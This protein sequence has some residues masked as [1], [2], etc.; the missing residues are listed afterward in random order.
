ML[1]P[2]FVSLESSLYASI[3]SF[4]IHRSMCAVCTSCKHND[5]RICTLYAADVSY[6][7]ICKYVHLSTCLVST[8]HCVRPSLCSPVH[9]F[10]YHGLTVF[11]RPLVQ[12][13]HHLFTRNRANPQLYSTV[14]LLTCLFT[15]LQ[16]AVS[17]SCWI[18]CWRPAPTRPRPTST[19]RTRST[20]RRRCA[21]QTPVNT[22]VCTPTRCTTQCRCA[23]LTPVNL[24]PFQAP[25]TPHYVYLSIS[26]AG[27]YTAKVN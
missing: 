11:T 14:T 2:L 8:C 19:E 10:I 24:R 12:S 7:S 13:T 21:D 26:G 16:C 1:F 27:T 22:T 17:W 15:R 3:V 23:D 5:G 4:C 18:F 6:D 9:L 20:T 25:I